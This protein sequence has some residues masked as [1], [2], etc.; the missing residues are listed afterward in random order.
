MK[1]RRRL[2]RK[3]DR[4]RLMTHRLPAEAIKPSQKDTPPGS[5]YAVRAA[6]CLKL[7][8]YNPSH[9]NKSNAC[10]MRPTG[11]SA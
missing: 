7:G 1:R 9:S 4:Q 3:R 10:A 8:L 6:P 11:A 2:H 5:K